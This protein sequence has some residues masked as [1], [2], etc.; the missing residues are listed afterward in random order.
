MRKLPNKKF[1]VIH[2]DPPWSF[3][4]WSPAGEGR[5][6]KRHYET[7]TTKQICSLP[8]VDI[9]A[10]D[11]VLF[12]WAIM[13]ML[14][15]AFQAIKAW[16]FKFKTVGFV[17]VKQNQNAPRLFY[18]GQDI[19]TGMGYYTRSNC[20][21][22]IIATRGKP[23]RLSANVSQPILEPIRAHSRKPA[24]TYDRIEKLFSGPY[25]DLFART[26]RR[27]WATWGNDTR[28]FTR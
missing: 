22:C 3:K 11:C 27:G 21:I 28:K 19:F 14:P 2:C 5:S 8:V 9:A 6:A 1:G 20:E 7:M 13:P 17:W 4:A 10:K 25:C 16:G 26:E 23:K 18:D 15:E 24:E 12:L